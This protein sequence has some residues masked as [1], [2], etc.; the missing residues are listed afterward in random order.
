[1]RYGMNEKNLISINIQEED[2]NAISQAIGLIME[3]LLPVLKTISPEEIRQL[4]K[5]GDKSMAFVVKAHE[6][7][8]SNPELIPQYVDINEFT[9]DIRAYE[10]LRQYYGPIT[11]IHD[12]IYHSMLL[13]GTD[14]FANARAFYK[15][16]RIGKSVN[17]PKAGSIYEDLSGRYPR[18]KKQ[19]EAAE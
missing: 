8:L 1:M 12:M 15:S 16:M 13:A 2:A 14:A 18:R 19:K 9:L 7:C 4:Y 5:M 3:K 17:M 10:Q 11:Q 6:H